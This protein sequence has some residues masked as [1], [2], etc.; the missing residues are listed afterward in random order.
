MLNQRV[1]EDLTP[2]SYYSQLL[3]SAERRYSTYEKECLAVLFVCEKCRNYLENKEFVFHCVILA[4][5]W[6]LKRVKDIGR[7]DRRVLRLAPLN[8]TSSTPEGTENVVPGALSRVFEGMTCGGLELPFAVLI[9][10][11]SLAYSSLSSIMVTTHCVRKNSCPGG[12]ERL[13]FPC[14]FRRYRLPL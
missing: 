10:S 9:E 8:F 2:V 1:G 3:S 5:R 7:L 11:L 4:V 12:H 13:I 14:M 6:I